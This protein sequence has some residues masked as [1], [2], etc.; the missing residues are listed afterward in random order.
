[1]I[2][3]LD[4]DGVLHPQYEGMPTPKEYLFCHL[5][6]FEAVWRSS[7]I[8]NDNDTIPCAVAMHASRRCDHF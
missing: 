1:M 3:F 2:F 8:W 7:I 6:R 4:F 5:S